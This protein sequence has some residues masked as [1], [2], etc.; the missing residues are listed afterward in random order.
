LGERFLG[1]DHSRT[2]I[3]YSPI[4][5]SRLARH[6]VCMTREKNDEEKQIGIEP[7]HATKPFGIW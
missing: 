2:H 6:G 7:P 4:D 5:P 1:P 3:G